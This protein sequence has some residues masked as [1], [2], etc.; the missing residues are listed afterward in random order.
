MDHTLRLCHRHA[1]QLT[2]EPGEFRNLA[3]EVSV[4]AERPN[5]RKRCR[6]ILTVRVR[7]GFRSGIRRL[8]QALG[9]RIAYGLDRILHRLTRSLSAVARSTSAVLTM[10]SAVDASGAPALATAARSAFTRDEIDGSIG[11]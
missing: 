9:R 3:R 6:S 7:A 2:P 11:S 5:T 1:L 10:A 4:S 8:L